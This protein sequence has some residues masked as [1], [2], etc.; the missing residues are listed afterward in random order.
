MSKRKQLGSDPLFITA[1]MILIFV[2]SPIWIPMA[3]LAC[4]ATGRSLGDYNDAAN[5][6]S[7]MED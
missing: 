1:L 3:M 5:A 7:G 6:M 2:T 4:I